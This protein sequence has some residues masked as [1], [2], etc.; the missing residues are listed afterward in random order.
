MKEVDVFESKQLAPIVVSVYDRQWH[1]EQCINALLKNDLAGDSILY[2]VSD[3]PS[4]PEHADAIENVRKYIDTISGFKEVR[5]IFHKNNLGM[6]DSS[7]LAHKKV[8]D[9]HDCMIRMEDDIVCSAH[10]LEYMNEALDLY[11]DNPKIFGI[12][13]YNYPKLKM[14]KDYRYNV[15]IWSSFSTWGFG[16]WRDRYNLVDFQLKRYNEFALNKEMQK[17]FYRIR[18]NSGS[19]TENAMGQKKY[20]DIRYAFH[21]FM[22]DL[23]AIYP[24]VSL[25]KNIGNDGMGV[26]CGKNSALQNQMVME[27]RVILVKDLEPNPSVYRRLYWNSFSFN[28][29]VVSMLLKKIGCFDLFYN[30]YRRLRGMR[31]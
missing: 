15:Y 20:A 9:K 26:H 17:R 22:H 18:P 5:K 10:Y 14:P 27:D 12:C 8:F 1:L 28:V 24:I 19:L 2:V 3:G 31:V 16:I 6:F 25:T 23:Y 4:K 11:A 7:M 21:M 30:F 29:H 13:A